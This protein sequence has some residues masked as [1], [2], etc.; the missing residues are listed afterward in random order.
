MTPDPVVPKKEITFDIKGTMKDDIVAGD[1]LGIL[2]YDINGKHTLGDT[3]WFDI[4]TSP[5]VTCPIKAKPAF[6]I[7]HN[8]TVPELP[9]AYF[10][11]IA[12]GHH[13]KVEP[14]AC[15]IAY[16]GDILYF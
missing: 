11:E 9:S 1:W 4:C 12:I 3:Y 6:S 13:E 5:G 10:I 14:I 2:F 7:T 15:A 16:I 8:Y